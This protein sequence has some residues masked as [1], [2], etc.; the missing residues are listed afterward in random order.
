MAA[1]NLTIIV[2]STA[3]AHTTSS[4][5]PSSCI[6]IRTTTT[7][8]TS[9]VAT[10]ATRTSSTIADNSTVSPAPTANG[11]VPIFTGVFIVAQNATALTAQWNLDVVAHLRV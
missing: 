4:P 5:H 11:T 6:D 7:F 2:S 1:R 3:A 8:A 10:N 9:S